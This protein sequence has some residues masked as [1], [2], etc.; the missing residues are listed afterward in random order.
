MKHLD[1]KFPAGRSALGTASGWPLSTGVRAL[2]GRAA[3]TG[4]PILL[5]GASGDWFEQLAA[6][7]HAASD[8]DHLQVVDAREG[9]RIRF[10][11]AAIAARTTLAIDGIEHL[12]VHAQERLL[13]D[14]GLLNPRLVC[15]SEL[16]S[17]ELR[18]VLLPELH[19]LVSTI[20]LET[21]A[22]AEHAEQLVN[23]AQ[24]RLGE[25]AHELHVIA[26]ELGPN[27]LEALAGHDWP[28]GPTE[29]DGVLVRTLLAR[30]GSDPIAAHELVWAS[31]VP[32]DRD[33]PPPPATHVPDEPPVEEA[34]RAEPAPLEE[35][36][37]PEPPSAQALPQVAAAPPEAPASPR[38]NGHTGPG[39]TNVE[40][41]AVELAHHLKNPLVTLKTFVA[42]VAKLGEDPERLARFRNLADES[43]GRMDA[44]LDELLEYARLREG[45]TPREVEVMGCLRAALRGVWQNLEAKGVALEGP[46]E[47]ELASAMGPNHLTFALRTL[48]NY[49]EEA[50]EPRGTLTISTPADQRLEL[51][52]PEAASQRHL[53]EAI[54]NGDES[55]PLSL[56]LVRGALTRAGA[57]LSAERSEDGLR[58]ILGFPGA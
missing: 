44:T 6:T 31:G 50:V 42:N 16:A 14:L 17:S 5:C 45:E 57:S 7:I 52:F 49:L 35:A 21:P 39:R 54:Q 8:R 56:L 2:L 18:N 40:A 29:L 38:A 34:R 43:I 33:D 13:D 32:R 51:R 11:S 9:D 27:A 22:V 53:R 58:L 36:A 37:A 55:F 28:G 24:L 25:I 4:F 1:L 19:G 20:D 23:A 26:P 12:D 10:P 30:E 47:A 48:A 46:V 15:G 41:L 3:P